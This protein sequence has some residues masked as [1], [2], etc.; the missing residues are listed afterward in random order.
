M[1]KTRVFNLKKKF[2][3]ALSITYINNHICS[4][5]FSNVLVIHFSSDDS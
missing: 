2:F 3:S 1:V 4:E 5:V